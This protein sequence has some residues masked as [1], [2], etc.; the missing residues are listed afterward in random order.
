MASYIGGG[1]LQTYGTYVSLSSLYRFWHFSWCPQDWNSLRIIYNSLLFTATRISSIV[2]Q[3]SVLLRKVASHSYALIPQGTGV[4]T[5]V[6]SDSPE[7]FQMLVY[8]HKKPKFYNVD[9]AWVSIDPVPVLCTSTYGNMTAPALVEALKI[10]SQKDKIRLA[11]VKEVAYKEGFYNGTM[12]V[13]E[14]SGERVR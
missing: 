10:Q 12:I 9:L 13:G 8:L 14:F 3:L 5:S 7:D 6:P 4:V 1:N 2:D 11:E